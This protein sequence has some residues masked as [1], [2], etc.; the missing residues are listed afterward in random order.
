LEGKR[1]RIEAIHRLWNLKD[2][3]GSFAKQFQNTCLLFQTI[4][5]AFEIIRN[6]VFIET[7]KHG[8]GFS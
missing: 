3:E 7:R 4:F 6:L 2:R 5:K 8:D 1:F